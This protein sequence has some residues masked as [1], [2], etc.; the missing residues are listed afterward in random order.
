MDAVHSAALDLGDK[1]EVKGQ[2]SDSHGASSPS[3]T[4][5]TVKE[6]QSAPESSPAPERPEDPNPTGHASST[7]PAPPPVPKVRKRAE[8]PPMLLSW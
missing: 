2:S 7:P 6:T 4:T 1:A 3:V 8:A 5:E